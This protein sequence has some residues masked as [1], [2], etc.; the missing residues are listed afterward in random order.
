MI[1]NIVF[2]LGGVLVPLNRAACEE[3]FKA[4]GFN[5]FGK[6][7]NEYVQGGFFLDYEKGLLTTKEF[8]DIL[9][10]YIKGEVSDIQI[11]KAMGSFLEQIPAERLDLL[12]SLKQRF[13]IYMLSNT[14]E[15]AMSVVKPFFDR[16]N[17]SIENYFDKLFLSYEM[18]MAKP[19]SEIFISMSQIADFIPDETLFI[20]DAP[21]NIETACSLGYKTLLI[22]P[23]MDLKTEV[24]RIVC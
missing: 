11:D 1:K 24:E 14:N 22:K 4:I 13:K 15:I 16:G 5:D 2:D 19:D 8:R 12:L 3:A 21:A 18:R 6:M 17:L 20:D 7:L 9:R 10:G 23:G